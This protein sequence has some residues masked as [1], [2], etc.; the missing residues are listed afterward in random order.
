MA[1]RDGRGAGGNDQGV[2]GVG[3][4]IADQGKWLLRSVWQCGC[5][6]KRFRFQNAGRVPKRFI[7]SGAL[8]AVDIGGPVV[9]F[10]R[11]HQLA[12]LEPCR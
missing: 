4:N 9:D 12:A 8:H 1:S 11:G 3:S 6:H 10:G 5:G 7:S 2:A